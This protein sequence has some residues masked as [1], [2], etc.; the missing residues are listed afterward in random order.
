[1]SGAISNIMCGERKPSTQHK[2]HPKKKVQKRYSPTTCIHTH[3]H[4]HTHAHVHTHTH[5]HLL[6]IHFMQHC[7]IIA[8]TYLFQFMCCK[9]KKHISHQR[10]RRQ[11]GCLQPLSTDAHTSTWDTLAQYR[12]SDIIIVITIKFVAQQTNLWRKSS[13]NKVYS[14]ALLLCSLYA[15]R[16]CENCH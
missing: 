9:Q 10:E 14:K 15:I 5:I 16:W 6:S 11:V 4:T 3:T 2:E 7:H 13:P 8:K 1:M 12:L